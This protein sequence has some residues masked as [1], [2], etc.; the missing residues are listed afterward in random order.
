MYQQTLVHMIYVQFTL[1]LGFL[2]FISEHTRDKQIQRNDEY[3]E[4]DN[5][6]DQN[7]DDA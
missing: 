4:G 5:D 3:Y 2:L 6:N 7:M 1:I